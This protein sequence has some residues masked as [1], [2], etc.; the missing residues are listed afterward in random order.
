MNNPN[1]ASDKPSIHSKFHINKE[2]YFDTENFKV[3]HK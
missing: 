2:I 3:E 1:V